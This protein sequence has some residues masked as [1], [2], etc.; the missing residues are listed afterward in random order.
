MVSVQIHVYEAVLWLREASLFWYWI[1]WL[2][3]TS[4]IPI[5]KN[6][7]PSGFAEGSLTF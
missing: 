3:A 2:T 5:A 7:C 1:L 4:T 6:V